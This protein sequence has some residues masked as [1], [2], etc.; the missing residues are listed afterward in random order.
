VRASRKHE[1]DQS[2]DKTRAYSWRRKTQRKKK[3]VP[4]LLLQTQANPHRNLATK[5]R[6]HKNKH[7]YILQKE[8]REQRVGWKKKIDDSGGR[9]SETPQRCLGNE[10]G[11]KGQKKKPTFTNLTKNRRKK[12]CVNQKRKNEARE[13]VFQKIFIFRREIAKE[14]ERE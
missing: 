10:T 1:K 12:H 7:Y 5:R 6:S 13:R 11:A 9:E 2:S 8:Y 3:R 14:P 4:E